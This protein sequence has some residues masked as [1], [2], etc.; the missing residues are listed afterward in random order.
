MADLTVTASKVR[1]LD[2]SIT[3]RKVLGGSASVGD[4]VTL[5]TDGTIIKT[6]G[7]IAFGIITSVDNKTSAGVSGD[8]V[9]VTVLGPVAGFSSLSPGRLGYVSAT[10]GKIA[11]AGSAVFGYAE[12]DQTFFVLPSASVAA[13]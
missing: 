2:G 6:T 10:D 9:A 13:S 12:D 7:A 1:P 3:R 11:D 5:Q 8:A 4:I